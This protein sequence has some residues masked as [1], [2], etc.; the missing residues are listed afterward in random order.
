M[1]NNFSIETLWKEVSFIPNIS[2]EKAIKH[3]DGALF[4]TAGPGSGK[5]RVLLWRTLNLIVFHNIKP[6]EILLATF[7][8]KAAHQLKEGLQSL[9]G[10]ASNHTGKQYDLA[11]MYIGT[12][13]SACNRIIGDRRFF[14]NR[15]RN[16]PVKTI[17]QLEQY[18]FIKRHSIWNRLLIAGDIETIEIN[19]YFQKKS[20]SFPNK[21]K[22]ILECTALFNRFSE[23]RLDIENALS[24]TDEDDGLC[25]I[26]KMYQEYRN[27][28]VEDKLFDQSDLSLIQDK[29]L[30]V[31]ENY[32]GAKKIF[33]YLIVDEYQ[34]TNTIQE[35]LYF[36]LAGN[37][38]ICVV[39]DD[40]QALYR[41]RGSTVE[42][43]VEFPTRVQK[44]LKVETTKI[45]LSINYRSRKKIVDFYTEFI[46]QEDWSK[47]GDTNNQYRVHDKGINAF[48]T[49]S[50]PSVI[51]VQ[52]DWID[53]TA[54]F[55]N[56]LIN[57]NKVSDANQIAFLFPSLTNVDAQRTII[58]LRESGLNVY[59][60]RAGR[61]LEGQEASELFG[62]FANV[63]G[64]PDVS[65]FSGLEF[66]K[67]KAWL[68]EIDNTGK[69][70][71]SKDSDLSKFV[72]HKKDELEKVTKDFEA[73]LKVVDKNN[74]DLDQDFDLNLMRRKLAE[75]INLSV[76]AKNAILSPYLARIVNERVKDESQQAFKI[77]QII[78][79]ATSLDWSILDLFYQLTG[80]S[81]FKHYFDLAQNEGNEAPICNLSKIVDYIT[82]FMEI[83]SSIL[84]A[85]FLREEGFIR[86]FFSSYLYTIYRMGESEYE[87]D[88]DPFPKGNIQVLTIHQSKGL[89]F[90]VVFMYP[91]RMEFLEADKKEV[92]IRNLK[93][94]DGEPL[95]KIGRFDLMRIFYVGLSRAEK[96]LILPK[97]RP[98]RARKGN[99][100]I[101][102]INNTLVS[103]GACDMQSF[104]PSTLNINDV[105]E[106]ALS[107]PYSYTADYLAYDRCPRQYMI[108]RKYGFIPSR[109]QTMFFGSL[110]HSTIEDLHELLIS[111]REQ[112]A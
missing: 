111:K 90:P 36:A 10:L 65:E 66:N 3:L 44:Y 28:L 96:L 109:S 49:D 29:A 98:V 68:K 106:S 86:L 13:H 4:L 54:Q 82:K 93:E 105:K 61:F 69:E 47:N 64:T 108:F 35:Q 33:K 43:F 9:L 45:P 7:T 72:N 22:A 42:N 53:Q 63:F 1:S 26:L 16:K 94:I 48:S 85:S 97:L 32:E 34:D 95:D 57:N 55:C 17:D 24:K 15:S 92:I 39:G 81:H 51:S 31:V 56:D 8:E 71:I 58:A 112:K 20:P 52:D 23:E 79:R 87:N 19:A 67:Y 37:K 74:W 62:V 27:I 2:Q 18:F 21:H 30:Q 107:K 101:S 75:A 104:D 80:F 103:T 110:V 100:T 83:Y 11:S 50:G 60:P 12:V 25:A 40:D 14:E 76:G 78:N 99:C 41:F 70:I 91:K 73:L 46:E 102:Y 89:E 84:S 88:D 59:A 38:N 6:D 5:T 77:S